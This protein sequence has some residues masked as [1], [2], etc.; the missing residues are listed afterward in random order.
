M[1]PIPVS[2]TG[3]RMGDNRIAQCLRP[4]GMFRFLGPFDKVQETD[5]FRLHMTSD[6]HTSMYRTGWTVIE[7]CNAKSDLIGRTVEQL[8]SEYEIIRPVD[9]S[10][11][12]TPLYEIENRTLRDGDE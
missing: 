9:E 10:G 3:S 2:T 11:G 5:I 8:G 4:I 12:T 1:N 6:G 7:E